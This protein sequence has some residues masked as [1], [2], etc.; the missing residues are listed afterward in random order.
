M[1]ILF[2]L[3][4][5]NISKYLHYDYHRTS[6]ISCVWT[7]RIPLFFGWK[8]NYNKWAGKTLFVEP[9]RYGC[10]INLHKMRCYC[11]FISNS[12]CEIFLWNK[13]WICL[14]YGSSYMNIIWVSSGTECKTQT[15]HNHPPI[16][17]HCVMPI[18]VPQD[19][20]F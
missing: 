8:G 3:Y 7:D 13:I 1:I 12:K 5:L 18:V 2:W 19:W 11:W 6:I 15:I 10:G 17:S 4:Y 9:F 16:S 14:F 20:P